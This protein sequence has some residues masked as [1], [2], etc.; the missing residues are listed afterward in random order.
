[1][2]SFGLS[3]HLTE[4]PKSSNWSSGSPTSAVYVTVVGLFSDF[5]IWVDQPAFLSGLTPVTSDG[6]TNT[7]ESVAF[8]S[9]PWGIRIENDP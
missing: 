9:H 2:V 6:I 7:T 8:A 5:S 4:K 3:G 1:M